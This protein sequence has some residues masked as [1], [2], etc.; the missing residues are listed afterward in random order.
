MMMMMMMMMMMIERSSDERLTDVSK[1][2]KK[3][4]H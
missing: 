3:Q 1:I 4:R 2:D